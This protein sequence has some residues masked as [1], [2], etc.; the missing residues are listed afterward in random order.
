MLPRVWLPYCTD[1]IKQKRVR[2]SYFC[3]ENLLP[4]NQGL[5]NTEFQKGLVYCDVYEQK[6]KLL[7]F[8]GCETET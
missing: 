8:Q 2:S 7:F 1:R 5:L 3:K 4:K 6:L